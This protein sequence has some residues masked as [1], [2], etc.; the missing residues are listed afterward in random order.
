M[1]SPS[2]EETNST[3]NKAPQPD[4]RI[5]EWK[6][7]N[8]EIKTNSGRMYAT[9]GLVIGGTS[10]LLKLAAG[11]DGPGASL[12]CLLPFVLLIPASL[13]VYSQ[14]NSTARIAAYIRV[15][16]ETTESGLQWETRLDSLKSLPANNK[17]VKVF[18]SSF[19]NSITKILAGLGWV[20]IGAGLYFLITRFE[21]NCS[22]TYWVIVDIF[23]GLSLLGLN[24]LWITNEQ[25][26]KAREDFG[27]GYIDDWKTVKKK[28]FSDDQS[29]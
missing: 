28:A 10:A 29:S 4:Y 5:E 11:I 14:T 9:L 23:T 17:Q 21:P 27:K 7:L 20:S 16:F 1:S 26:K 3:E 6:R 8:D 2:T 25:I 22:N 13:F 12:F 15:F 19:T 24:V 18:G